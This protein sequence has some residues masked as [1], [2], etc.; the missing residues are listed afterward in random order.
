VPSHGAQEILCYLALLVM[1]ESE[2]KR[3]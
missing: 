2:S 3:V 1:Q